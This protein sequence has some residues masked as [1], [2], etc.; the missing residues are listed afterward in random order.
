MILRFL[1]SL[2]AESPCREHPLTDSI[3]EV[4]TVEI[5]ILAGQLQCLIPHKGVNTKIWG[6]MKFYKVSL[7]FGAGEGVH[8]DTQTLHQSVGSRNTPI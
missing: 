7:A 4:F 2:D 6:E 1:K 5:W 8:I 3:V